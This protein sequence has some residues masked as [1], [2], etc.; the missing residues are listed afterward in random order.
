MKIRK[1][2]GKILGNQGKIREFH[3]IK[4]W[5]PCILYSRVC[6][7]T[8]TLLQIFVHILCL[9]PKYTSSERSRKLNFH[10]TGADMYYDLDVCTFSRNY[11]QYV[12]Y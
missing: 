10:W 3:R 5:E 11:F 9:C 8:Y 7:R 6:A 1:N 2:Q 4:K 12:Q